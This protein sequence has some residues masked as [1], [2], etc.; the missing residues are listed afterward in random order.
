MDFDLPICNQKWVHSF[1]FLQIPKCASSS[2]HSVC[3]ERNLIHKHRGL[4][5]ARFGK[6]PLYKGIFDRRHIVPEHLFQIFNGQVW[7]FMSFCVVRNP[8]RR[9]IS[10]YYFGREKK[11]HGVYGLKEDTSLDEYI[12]WLYENRKSKNILILLPQIAWADNG[13]FPVEILRFENLQKDWKS[14]LL[15]YQIQGLPD[16]L[17]HEN[18]SQHGDWREEISAESLKLILDFTQEDRILYPE[19]YV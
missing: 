5:E 4:I 10:S 2:I 17:P 6:H 9:V 8:I 3:G 13:I 18:K 12:R 14:L 16:S 15:K 19:L 7:E 1:F 11:L